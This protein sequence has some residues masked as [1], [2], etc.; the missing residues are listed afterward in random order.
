M[1]NPNEYSMALRAYRYWKNKISFLLPMDRYESWSFFIVE[2]GNFNY[3][4]NGISDKAGAG[5]IVVCP[6]NT[7]F[8]RRIEKGTLTFHYILF[9]WREKVAEA[10]E[11]VRFPFLAPPGYKFRIHDTERFLSTVTYLRKN[12]LEVANISYKLKEHFLN[13]LLLIYYLENMEQV[14]ATKLKADPIM[15]EVRAILDQQVFESFLLLDVAARFHLSKVQ[16]TRRFHAAFGLNPMEY[17]TQLRIKKA[18]SL[19]TGTN[20]TVDHI[21]QLCGYDNGF[22][23]SRV[24]LKFVGMNPSQFRK[25]HS[26]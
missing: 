15:T 24:F 20:Y 23:F 4:I 19:L 17:V 18:I 9:D 26:V 2:N 13:E 25:T 8:H 22:Y 21:A 1:P 11:N 6:P 12:Y 10:E 16:L 7:D 14:N 3:M 5:D